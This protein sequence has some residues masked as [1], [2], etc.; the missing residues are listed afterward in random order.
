M[1]LPITVRGIY[2]LLY[3][4]KLL[5]IDRYLVY[6]YVYGATRCCRKGEHGKVCLHFP[7]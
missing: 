1:Y 4:C 2:M 6:R 3:A 7:L 5:Y